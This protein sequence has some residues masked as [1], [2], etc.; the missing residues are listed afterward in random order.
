[1]STREKNMMAPSPRLPCPM[2]S[3]VPFLAMVRSG[4]LEGSRVWEG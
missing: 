2:V 1:M 3:P 4:F